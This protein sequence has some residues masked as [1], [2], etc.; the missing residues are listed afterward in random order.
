M[1]LCFSYFG[2]IIICV[3]WPVIFI[4]L[5]ALDIKSS[6]DYNNSEIS[7]LKFLAYPN[8]S[9][10]FNECTQFGYFLISS[11]ASI[12][13]NKLCGVGDILSTKLPLNSLRLLSYDKK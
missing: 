12:N 1:F 4:Y 9:K 8:P 2:T 13:W 10:V 5:V 3:K 6:I 11:H 7:Q